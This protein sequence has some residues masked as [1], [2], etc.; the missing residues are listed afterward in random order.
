MSEAVSR[1]FAAMSRFAAELATLIRRAGYRSPSVPTPSPDPDR[2]ELAA[3]IEALMGGPVATVY[4]K[5]P[6]DAP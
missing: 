3:N 2:S 4:D 6:K 5:P 1:P